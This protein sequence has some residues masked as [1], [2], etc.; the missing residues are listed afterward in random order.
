M[1]S[2]EQKQ[3]IEDVCAASAAHL[4]NCLGEITKLPACEQFARLQEHFSTAFLA[5]QEGLTGWLA[6]E[7]SRN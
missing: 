2:D 4:F 3:L 5:Y 6:P 7:P 1:S